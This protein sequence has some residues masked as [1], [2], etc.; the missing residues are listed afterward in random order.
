MA[1]RYMCFVNPTV[2]KG[3]NFKPMS[4]YIIFIKY[5]KVKVT[6]MVYKHADKWDSCLAGADILESTLSRI[7]FNSIYELALIHLGMYSRGI[8]TEVQ[9]IIYIK[10]LTTV[11]LMA[12]GRSRGIIRVHHYK[13]G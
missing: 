10:I 7:L 9:K 3:M 4:K 8:F 1:N 6:Y 5:A 11:V 2:I 13:N 12:A